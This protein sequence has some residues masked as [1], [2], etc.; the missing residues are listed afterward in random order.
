MNHYQ[1][2]QVDRAASP[3]VIE[4]AYRRLAKMYH[5]DVNG[6]SSA[7]Q[8]MQAINEAYSVLRDPVGRLAYDRHLAWE[9]LQT[10]HKQSSSR[11]TADP[12][13][14]G[15]N[16]ATKTQ[17]E[18]TGTSYTLPFNCASCGRSDSTLRLTIFPYV[19][20]FVVL[21]FRR[22]WHGV[23]C[24]SCRRKEMSKAKLIT[25]LFG[26]WGIP[27]GILFAVR[28]LF[29]ASEGVVLPQQNAAYLRALGL[30]FWGERKVFSAREA[31][32][33]SLAYEWD[34]DAAD[35]YYKAFG[36]IPDR[37]RRVSHGE[38]SGAFVGLVTVA[39]TA[40]VFV[41]A[42]VYL[43]MLA[44][45]LSGSQAR[46]RNV[47]VVTPTPSQVAPKGITIASK[48]GNTAPHGWSKYTNREMEFSAYIPR[49][50]KSTQV[51][52]LPGN[53]ASRV[54]LEPDRGITIEDRLIAITYVPG[55]PGQMV[56]P[57]DFDASVRDWLATNKFKAISPPSATEIA[58]YE[59]VELEYEGSW[60]DGEIY[61]SQAAFLNV[62]GK[63]FLIEVISYPK[64]A[65]TED[66]Y[67]M[68]INNFKVLD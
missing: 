50:Y 10:K 16:N 20:S 57:S 32:E 22:Q 24:Q 49:D 51:E 53:P 2:L 5:P 19:V 40:A 17:S 68:F 26:W 18:P 27:F 48:L 14:H 62:P 9:E 36:A 28:Y 3:E 21:T 43:G 41:V 15:N 30:W 45:P 31:I 38:V 8:K 52:S 39:V 12:N 34:A 42:G 44:N 55:N 60:E 56:K 61:N 63:V 59:A 11:A 67:H 1:V 35:F 47:V 23:F 58:G 64:I 33:N 37:T 4:A 13:K 46:L 6:D 25:A 66:F 54:V 29:F 65:E 7:Q